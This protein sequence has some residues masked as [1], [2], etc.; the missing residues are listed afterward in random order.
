IKGKKRRVP[1]QWVF[2][3]SDIVPGGVYRGDRDGHLVSVANFASSVIDVPFESSDANAML[4][5]EAN[6]PA[7][8]PLGQSVE[9]IITPESGAEKAPHARAT[10]V[11]DAT[12]DFYLDG[13]KVGARDTLIGLARNFAH[14]HVEGEVVVIANRRARIG[15]IARAGDQL[16]RGGVKYVRQQWPASDEEMLPRTPL[17]MN[18]ALARWR[19]MFANADY[20]I[21]HPRRQC[22]ETLE[23]ISS[24]RASLRARRELLAE[25]AAKLR[26]MLV[27]RKSSERQTRQAAS[28]PPAGRRLP[29]GKQDSDDGRP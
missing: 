13:R 23:R 21:V 29:R 2:V 11:V 28:R 16:R 3:G 8:P 9:V 25:Y 17:Q 14:K 6:T 22:A 4:G 10:L 26:E 7:I 19:E 27:V 20:Y 15:D 5:F 24:E 12:G 1:E 18:T